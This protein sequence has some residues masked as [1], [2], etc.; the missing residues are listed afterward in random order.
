MSGVLAKGGGGLPSGVVGRNILALTDAGGAVKFVRVNADNSVTLLTQAEV[1]TALGFGATGVSLSQ[2]ATVAEARG[3][4]GSYGGSCAG[5]ETA[6]TQ[7]V[8]VDAI[9][10]TLPA[11]KYLI[12]LVALWTASGGASSFRLTVDPGAVGAAANVRFGSLFSASAAGSF[13]WASSTTSN[14]FGTSGTFASGFGVIELS[15]A[16]TVKLQFTNTA[17]SGSVTQTSTTS[18][19]FSVI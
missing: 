4:I 8:W 17:A 7:N 12:Q 11:A 1:L 14:A 18:M 10:V 3:K 16:A 5:T 13:Q 19:Q 9:S 15:S 6:T 2:A